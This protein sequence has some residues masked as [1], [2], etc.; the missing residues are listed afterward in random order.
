MR[1][2]SFLKKRGLIRWILIGS[3]LSLLTLFLVN[4]SLTL[5]RLKKGQWSY[6]FQEL[7]GIWLT[8]IDSD[9][10]FSRQNLTTAINRLEK[11]HF[12]TLYPTVWQG[13]YTLYPSEVAQRVLGIKIDPISSLQGRDILQEMISQAHPKGLAV[14]PWLEFGFMLPADSILVQKHP[15]WLTQKRDGS[16][17]WKEGI[18]E[19]VWLN[20]FHPEVQ[21]FILDLVLEIVEKYEI[22]GIQFDDHW[23]LP[24]EFG[25]DPFTVKMYE[26]EIQDKPSDNFQ[27]TFWIRWRSDQLNQF[28]ERVFHE[29]KSRKK[30]C[31][32]SLSPNPLHFSL[33]AHLQ[34]WFTWERRGY[35]EEL[36]IQVY[37]SDL[38]RFIKELDR[39]EIKLAQTHIPVAIGILTGL[40]NRSVSM[41]NI[42]AQVQQVRNRGM[43]GVSFFFY[44]SLWNWGEESSQERERV[45][46]RLFP[47][48]VRRPVVKFNP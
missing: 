28:M 7:R 24:A 26:D 10:L 36:I 47:F 43:G 30:R 8:N 5:E 32:I 17:I 33:P 39:E 13:G 15:D 11:L 1:L 9:V 31:I 40:K 34:D 48:K 19:R 44:E 18:E 42:V 27:E 20:P 21:K 16:K 22:D 6:P 35:I 25:Y 14:I 4:P 23:S 45:L 37:R 12:N 29:V 46:Q 2:L 38:K 3:C 41:K